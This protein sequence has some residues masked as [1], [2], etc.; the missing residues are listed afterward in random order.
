MCDIDETRVRKLLI[1]TENKKKVDAYANQPWFV[2]CAAE[3]FSIMSSP[4]PAIAHFYSFKVDPHKSLTLAI[5]DG[6]IDIL[7]NG[8]DTTPSA[9]VYGSLLQIEAVNLIKNEH[10]IG[11]R[12]ANGIVPNFLDVSAKELINNHY[13]LLDVAPNAEKLLEQIACRNRVIQKVDS[14]QQYLH[15]KTLPRT[16][17]QLTIPI[18]R[19]ICQQKGNVRVKDLELLTGYT[20]RT[21][22]RAFMDDVGMSPKL[23][24]RI[25]RC[26]SAAYSLKHDHISFCDLASELGFSDQSH[27]LREFKQL[28]SSTPLE[29][30]NYV[31]QEEYANKL[32]SS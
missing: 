32:Q 21:L 30:I 6:C 3:K 8:N 29:Y 28:I 9:K 14:I 20:T 12:F 11:V 23:F 4:D 15:N 17:S 27:F 24:S 13:N 31:K 5:P 19:K 1:G 26:Q 22:Q 2:Q 10:Y 16:S 7:F 25:I 18:I